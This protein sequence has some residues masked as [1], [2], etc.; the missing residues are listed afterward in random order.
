M[1]RRAQGGRRGGYGASRG[2]S[3][4]SRGVYGRGFYT[5]PRKGVYSRRTKDNHSGGRARLRISPARGTTWH[6]Q[7]RSSMTATRYTPPAVEGAPADTKPPSLDN[8]TVEKEAPAWLGTPLTG[9]WAGK[10][11]GYTRRRPGKAR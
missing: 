6:R 1:A 5:A 9:R 11:S 7:G 2:R 10:A 4:G 8:S 3:R